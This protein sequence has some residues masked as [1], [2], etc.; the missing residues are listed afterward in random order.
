MTDE[1]VEGGEGTASSALGGAATG[2]TV[3]DTS[4]R[5]ALPSDLRDDPSLSPIE[6]LG[7]LAKSYISAQ[8]MIGAD[9]IVAPNEHTTDEQW[10]TIYNRLG[11]P[12]AA[13]KYELQVGDKDNAE[14]AT[15]FK[16]I[17]HKSGLSNKQVG[18]L[19]KWYNE[20]SNGQSN[21]MLA[22]DTEARTQKLNAFKQS[23]GEGFDPFL[24]VGATALNELE[25]KDDFKGITEWV[26]NTGLGDDP[27]LLKIMNLVGQSFMEDQVVKSGNITGF[28]NKSVA[29]LDADIASLRSNP[30][31]LDAQHPEHK[32]VH[33]K[34]TKLH[35]MKTKNKPTMGGT[36]VQSTF[37]H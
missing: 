27:M 34:M 31:W 13:D 6:T 12:E 19:F 5:E 2:Q 9:K 20:E 8:K 22:K 4:W 21:A 33:E 3:T 24:N 28:S 15:K 23:L 18:D 14:F 32:I 17:A 29:D 26:D 35:E 7:G 1:V 11:R 10:Q 30:A 25:K 16:E 37:Q 36:N